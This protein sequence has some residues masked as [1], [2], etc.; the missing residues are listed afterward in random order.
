MNG[1]IYKFTSP[2]N[3]VYIGIT[4]NLKERYYKHKCL[5]DREYKR[6]LYKAC[7]HYGFENMEFKVLEVVS[8]NS[9]DA[10]Y[11][12]LNE[13]EQYYIRQYDSF[14]NGYNCTLGGGGTK[15]VSGE[16]NSFYGK[17]HSKKTIALLSEKARR[18]T[19]TAETKQ[20]IAENTK[21]A[22]NNISR[23]SKMKMLKASMA[24]KQ[25]ICLD[26]NIIYNS[27]T[28][29]AEAYSST[30]SEISAVCKGKRITAKGAKF[31]YYKNGQKVE[32]EEPDNKRVKAIQCL[33]TG[34][35]FDSIK[36]ACEK[37]N[38]RH[39]HVSAILRGKQ[40]TTKGYS[41]KYI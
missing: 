38:V 23:E 14:K 21:K 17:K 34:E 33:E 8:A 26:T 9:E 7:R 29:C 27:V 19:H 25:V 37:L 1:Y 12:I 6:A 13:K 40:K 15:G 24:T 30:T 28:E 5:V 31:R 10:L 36:E 3:K 32:V 4:K 20:K 18:R 39:Q 16:R 2:S 22:L 11:N 35:K 41:F